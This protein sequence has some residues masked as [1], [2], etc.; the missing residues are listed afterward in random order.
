M[1]WSSDVCSSDLTQRWRRLSVE[2]FWWQR[3]GF[4]SGKRA[5][6]QRRWLAR[7]GTAVLQCPAQQGFGASPGNYAA[8]QQPAPAAGSYLGDAPKQTGRAAVRETGGRVR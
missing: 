2:Y 7:T 5:A 4:T 1:D 8:P 3:A 6:C